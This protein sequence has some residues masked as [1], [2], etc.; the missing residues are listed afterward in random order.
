MSVLDCDAHVGE[1]LGGL[2]GLSAAVSIF[3]IMARRMRDAIRRSACNDG[4]SSRI[5]DT[6]QP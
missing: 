2:A 3:E 4:M 1:Q 6:P 5:C